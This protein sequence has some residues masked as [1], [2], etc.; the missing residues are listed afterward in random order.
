MNYNKKTKDSILYL[1]SNARTYSRSID[2]IITKGKLARVYDSS[3]NEY[4]DCLSCAGALALGHNNP[5]IQE[6]VIDFLKSDQLQQALDIMTPA[7]I[8]FIEQ[9]YQILPASFAKHAKIQFCSPSGSDG[10][11]AALKLFKI[12]TGRS[13]IFV[14]QGAYHGMTMG[15]LSM[16]GNLLPKQS[17]HGYTSDVHFL[18]FPYTYRNPFGVDT[19]DIEKISLNYLENLLTDPE[20]G[21]TKPAMVLVETIQGEGGCIPASKEWLR[22]LREITERYDVPL[23]L[24]EIQC[25]CGRSGNM[26]AYEYSGIVPDAIILSKAIGGGYPLTVMLYHDKY[27][28]WLPG[29]HTGTFRGNQIALVSGTATLAYLSQPSI[30]ENINKI[31]LLLKQKLQ[32]LQGKF[33]CIGEVRG[34]GLMIGVELIK[35]GI[36]ENPLGHPANN[37]ELAKSLKLACLE[38]G[39]ILETG[40]RNKSVIR[41]LPPLI[42]TESDVNEIIYR[43]ESALS[44]IWKN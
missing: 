13:S 35:P 24:D 14:F 43:F 21:L 30:L 12:V 37:K 42:I 38:N 2:K 5:I 6:K 16:M 26:F 44:K 20:S 22:G 33:D 8:N 9:L 15:S 36:K 4:F 3:G 32:I 17:I 39:L 28:S 1:E 27:D 11:E 19:Y 23:V 34:Q 18:P 40:G 29:S 31:G 7:R 25:G 10:V 41:F